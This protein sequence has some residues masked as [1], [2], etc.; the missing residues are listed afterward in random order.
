MLQA[1]ETA[2][3]A[4]TQNTDRTRQLQ[5]AAAY[6]NHHADQSPGQSLDQPTS[7]VMGFTVTHCSSLKKQITAI[8]LRYHE[9]SFN[10]FSSLN[11]SYAYTFS[12]YH[13]PT[14]YN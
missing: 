1:K 6:G 11:V 2:E 12:T 7:Q 14:L 8:P 5:A 4:R 10:I 9:F 3:R 13:S